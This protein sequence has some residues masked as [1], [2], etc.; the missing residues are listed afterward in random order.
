MPKGD[1]LS[2]CLVL[3]TLEGYHRKLQTIGSESLPCRSWTSELISWSL[4]LLILEV[5][6]TAKFSQEAMGVRMQARPLWEG[7]LSLT[8]WAEPAER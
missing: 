7:Q 8:F 6:I 2:L 4:R 3:V 5:R 1:I